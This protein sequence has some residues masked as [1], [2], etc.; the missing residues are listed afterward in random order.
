MIAFAFVRMEF[1]FP[2]TK[3]VLLWISVLLIQYKN[4]IKLKKYLLLLLSHLNSKL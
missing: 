2:E 3:T 4:K 1:L